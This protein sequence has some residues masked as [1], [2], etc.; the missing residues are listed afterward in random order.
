M[1]GEGECVG[2]VSLGEHAGTG[3]RVV[4]VME[5]VWGWIALSLL[6]VGRVNILVCV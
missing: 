6:R 1:G 3:E 4:S 5:L 2:V